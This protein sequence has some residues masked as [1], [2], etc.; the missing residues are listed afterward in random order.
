MSQAPAAAKHIDSPMI[1]VTN[2]SVDDAVEKIIGHAVAIGASDLFILSNE[3]FV[4]VQARHLG[5]IRPLAIVGSEQGKRFM[6][7]IKANAGMEITETR[8]PHDGRWI[9]ETEDGAS[10]D[11]RINIIPTLYGEDFG[12]R[13]L[14]RESQLFDLDKI[15]MT[16]RQLGKFRSML[17]SPGGLVLIT[18][19]SG[20]GKTGTLYA[21]LRHLNNGTRKINT[22]EDPIEFSVE[23]LRQSQVSEAFG[24]TFADLLRSILRQNPDV[25]MVG[26]IRD[27]ETAETAVRAAN[28]GHMV[29]STLHAPVAA[30]AIQSMLSLG[31]HPHF[32]STALR[33]VVAQRLV[34]TLCP[35]CR[36]SFDI[37]HSPNTFDEVKDMLAKDEGKLLY[38]AR[39]CDKC[40]GSGYA[41]RSGVFEVMEVSKT[42]RAMVTD[43]KPAWE[44]RRQAISEGMLD[45]RKAAMLKV[46]RGITSTE[47]VFRTIPAEHLLL[48][49]E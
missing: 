37:S 42:L 29:F 27:T 22:I 31:V 13:L 1:D 33:G 26:E 35:D 41:G 48:D 47:E 15:G 44:V 46:A 4:A 25:I 3:S 12:I 8:R 28:S 17:D 34:R 39:G 18:G 16:D 24:L 38:G 2:L 49:E 10:V 36:V 11:L 30:A 21:A 32:L 40:K 19:P 20:S 14:V 23:G 43:A 6:Q 5:I 9:Y 45:F 7:H